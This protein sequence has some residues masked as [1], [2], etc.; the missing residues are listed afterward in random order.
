MKHTITQE[1][2][3]GCGAA[4]VAFAAN[5]TYRQV[6]SILGREKA[7]TVGYQLKELVDGLSCFGLSYQ[8]KY[9][10]PKINKSIYQ[11]G[12]IVFIRRSGKYPY[13]HYLIRH[14][15]LWIDPWINLVID[16]NLENAKSGYRQRLPGK[17][18]WAILPLSHSG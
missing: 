10:K 16:K 2:G 18:Q 1:D 3:M 12:V 9:V 14:N 4:C 11:D 15:G 8:Y 17:A 5:R 6:V 7:R 13:G